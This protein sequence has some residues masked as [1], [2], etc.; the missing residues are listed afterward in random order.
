MA[1]AVLKTAQ[2][3]Y[4]CPQGSYPIGDGICKQEPTG[5]PYGDSIP[6]DSP[7]CAP[8][9]TEEKQAVKK[10]TN[11]TTTPPATVNKGVCGK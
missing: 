2:A 11:K 10:K 7:K 5:C 4:S 1:G 6:L 3:E 9:T 8:Q